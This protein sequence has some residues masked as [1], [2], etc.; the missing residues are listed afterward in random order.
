MRK[1]VYLDKNAERELRKFA[2]KVQIEFEA[3]FE[4][5][6]QTGKLAFLES[7]KVDKNLFELRVKYKGEYRGFYAYIGKRYIIVL[8]FFRKKTQR[9]PIKHIRTAK[10]RL[11]RYE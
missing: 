5:L 7:K 11:R 4:I 2:E 1:K 8:L 3:Y 10:G 9:T 6:R